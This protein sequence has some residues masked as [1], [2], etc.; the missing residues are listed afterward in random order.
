MIESWRPPEHEL[1]EALPHGGAPVGTEPV[2]PAPE[3]SVLDRHFDL[4]RISSETLVW[5]VVLL[6]AFLVRIVGLTNWSLS[7]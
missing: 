1:D 3:R 6:I 2:S 4:S 5:G 7:A